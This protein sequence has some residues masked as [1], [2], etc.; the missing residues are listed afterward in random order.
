MNV[1]MIQVLCA[2]L[3][4][5]NLG[6][7]F[8]SE[9]SV[10]QWFFIGLIFIWSG[11][12]RSGL[13]F[14][15][16]ALA[17]PLLLLVHNDPLL[18][19]PIIAIQLLFFSS[20]IIYNNYKKSIKENASN[21]GKIK[22][23][24]QLHSIDWKYLKQSMLVIIIP[25]L[26]G[27]FGL[28]TLPNTFLSAIIFTVI[29]IYSISY[30]ID[31]PFQS[32]KPWVDRLFLIIGGYVSGTS[33]VGAPLIVAVFTS[34]VARE[35]LRDTLFVLWIVLVSIKITSFLIAGVDLQWQQQLWLLPCAAIGH[36]IGLR[37]YNYLQ[38]V[39]STTFY[40]VIGLALFTVSLIGIM[41]LF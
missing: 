16:A 6:G 11:F 23:V 32:N 36:V 31:K 17:L 25:K 34:H 13:G 18:F 22:T 27:V 3:V 10:I 28:L 37:F 26:L 15:G 8:M 1:S 38:K 24:P 40:R 9:L 21:D 5:D 41:Q 19:L 4:V 12:V 33:L 39:R 2:Y 29:A 35:Q 20:L 14:G 7:I 30:I